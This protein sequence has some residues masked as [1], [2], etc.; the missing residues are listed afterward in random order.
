MGKLADVVADDGIGAIRPE[1]LAGGDG[2]AASSGRRS[3]WSSAFEEYGGSNGRRRA[4]F[5]AARSPIPGFLG[6]N[7]EGDEGYK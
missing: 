4:Q 3:W 6:Q 5:R 7:G 2:A 1:F